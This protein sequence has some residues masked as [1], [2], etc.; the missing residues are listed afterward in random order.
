MLGWITGYDDDELGPW[1]ALTYPEPGVVLEPGRD[2][3]L[4]LS[5]IRGTPDGDPPRW[6]VTAAE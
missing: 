3:V 6:V 2:Y 1:A 4:T 5:A